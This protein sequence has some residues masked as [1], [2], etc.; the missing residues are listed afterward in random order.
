M[1]SQSGATFT[2]N[3]SLWDCHI[4][5]KKK[6]FFVIQCGMNNLCF[7][8]CLIF[9]TITRIFCIFRRLFCFSY[10]FFSFKVKWL[11]K[12]KEDEQNKMTILS[13]SSVYQ[14]VLPTSPAILPPR[15]RIYLFN[16]SM[17]ICQD[18]KIGVLL[19]EVM[20]LASLKVCI[21]HTHKNSAGM[22]KNSIFIQIEAVLMWAVAY[23][24]TQTHKCKFKTR[25][26][27][28]SFFVDNIILRLS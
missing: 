21:L 23:K 16:I 7:L 24:V 12:Q 9:L 17:V 6:R 19:L 2:I 14:L 15:P 20:L 10:L 18:W 25:Q 28:G 11:G 3:F 1:I 26:G 5:K 4:Y 8:F 13:K 22:N 27:Q